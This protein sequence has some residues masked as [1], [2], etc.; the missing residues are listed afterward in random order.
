MQL[1]YQHT[2]YICDILIIIQSLLILQ[3]I[4]FFYKSTFSLLCIHS[5]I[6]VKTRC[7]NKLMP[8]ETHPG[9]DI[10]KLSRDLLSCSKWVFF[11]T[12]ICVF[13][14]QTSD[15]QKYFFRKYYMMIF[16]TNILRVSE[17]VSMAVNTSGLY[18]T[19]YICAMLIICICNA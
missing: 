18:T 13:C 9:H 10:L 5:S 19:P 16:E 17:Y 11:N 15:T 7:S 4:G 2:S 1:H 3:S 6:E 12:C 8:L 14:R